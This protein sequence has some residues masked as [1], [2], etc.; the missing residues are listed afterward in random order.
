MYED[1]SSCHEL[2]NENIGFYCNVGYP[3]SS[4]MHPKVNCVVLCKIFGPELS[5][6]CASARLHSTRMTISSDKSKIH[7]RHIFPL[8]T[9]DL[10][11]VLPLILCWEFIALRPRGQMEK[12]KKAG[13][14]SDIPFCSTN[15]TQQIRQCHFFFFQTESLTAIVKM[16]LPSEH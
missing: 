12:R 1:Y 16:L 14:V 2:Y 13:Y 6:L 5:F 10:S 4:E 7:Q 8:N 15:L 3:K 9:T 11:K